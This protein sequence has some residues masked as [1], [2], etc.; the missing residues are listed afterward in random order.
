M[1][2]LHLTQADI[3]WYRLLNLEISHKTLLLTASNKFWYVVLSFPFNSKY[4]PIF[5][6]IFPFAHGLFWNV[7]FNF[8]IFW[9]FQDFSLL[10]NSNL[11]M[12]Y[13]ESIL[14]MISILSYLLRLVLWLSMCSVLKNIPCILEKN[15]YSAIAEQS[16][17]SISVRL[18][19]LIML[20]TSLS[21]II[22]CLAVLL[23]VENIE[24]SNYNCLISYFSW[25]FKCI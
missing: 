18:S 12:F 7:L 9:D 23:I 1:I 20:K 4:T 19:W 21:W 8:Q 11:I 14:C 25:V 24:I 13:S 16:I 6:M 2:W 17:L 22:S 3:S 5:L 10:L 15:I